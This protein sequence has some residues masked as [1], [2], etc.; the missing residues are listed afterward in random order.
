MGWLHTAIE[1]LAT[2]VW[3]ALLIAL[4]YLIYQISRFLSTT[5]DAI[6]F[7]FGLTTLMHQA[8]EAVG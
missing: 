5:P 6:Q 3:I 1:K 2:L 7:P 4:T 8:G